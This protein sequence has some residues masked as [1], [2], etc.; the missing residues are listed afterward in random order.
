VPFYP[1]PWSARFW[2][3]LPTSPALSALAF[4]GVILAAL[5]VIHWPAEN[6]AA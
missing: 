2:D 1:R 4:D 6:I 5:L 3:S